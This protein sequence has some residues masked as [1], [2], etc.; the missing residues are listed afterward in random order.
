[1]R[2][3][4]LRFNPPSYAGPGR[5]RRTS[6]WTMSQVDTIVMAIYRLKLKGDRSPRSDGSITVTVR[7]KL[8]MDFIHSR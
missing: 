7:L 2:T 4:I 1:M 5:V 8:F 6:R 3:R